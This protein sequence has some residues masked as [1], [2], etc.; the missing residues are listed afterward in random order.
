MGILSFIFVKVIQEI[1]WFKT[2]YFWNLSEKCKS[3]KLSWPILAFEG[4]FPISIF[5]GYNKW[6]SFTGSSPFKPLFPLTADSL[7]RKNFYS[8]VLIPLYTW[9]YYTSVANIA[10]KVCSLRQKMVSIKLKFLMFK[11]LVKNKRNNLQQE[12]TQCF[13]IPDLKILLINSLVMTSVFMS[14]SQT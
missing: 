6:A 10:S 3:V 5:L 14:D 9:K 2:W 7:I 4:Q 13:F 1:G 8:E 11:L 12:W